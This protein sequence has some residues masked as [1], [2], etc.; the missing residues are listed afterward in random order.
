MGVS[1]IFFAITLS[2]DGRLLRRLA[3]S[4]PGY[5]LRQTPGYKKPAKQPTSRN[6]TGDMPALSGGKFRDV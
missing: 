5:A 6:R 2:P 1:C 4:S 3:V